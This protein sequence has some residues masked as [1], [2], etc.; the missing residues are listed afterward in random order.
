MIANQELYKVKEKVEK[1]E[2]EGLP[3]RSLAMA[4]QI[5]PLPSNN[6][7]AM[8]Q[9]HYLYVILLVSTSKPQKP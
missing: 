6:I 8:H 9:Q 7:L 4:S 2:F 5:T 1:D 3:V